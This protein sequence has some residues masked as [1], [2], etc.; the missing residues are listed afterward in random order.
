MVILE[1]VQNVITRPFYELVWTVFIFTPDK[2]S[3]LFFISMLFT[4]LL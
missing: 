1:A 4:R 2:F 3:S